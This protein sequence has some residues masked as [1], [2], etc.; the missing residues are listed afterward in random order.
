MAL[1]R[2]LRELRA[3]QTALQHAG[4]EV[5]DSFVSLTEVSEYAKG[6]PAEMLQ[7]RLYPVLPPRRAS[8][9]GA[10]TR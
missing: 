8:R 3:L 10:S 5:V 2:D 4:L 1:H 6:M 7:P 9:R